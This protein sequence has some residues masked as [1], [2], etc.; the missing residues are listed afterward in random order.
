MW[1]NT[2]TEVRTATIA[3]GSRTSGVM[4]VRQHRHFELEASAMNGTA[5]LVGQSAYT[6]GQAAPAAAAFVNIMAADRSNAVALTTL[7]GVASRYGAAALTAMAGAHWVRFVA[8]SVQSAART[9][10]LTCKD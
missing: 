7:T 6:S 9:L 1:R 4:D 2:V 10:K 3:S 5:T 8:G